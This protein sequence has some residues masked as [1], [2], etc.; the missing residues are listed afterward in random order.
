MS[1]RRAQWLWPTA[2]KGLP[3]GRRRASVHSVLLACLLL[4]PL[5]A[6]PA[7][8]AV[9]RSPR[10]ICKHI[11]DCLD[12]NVDPNNV[13][14]QIRDGVRTRNGKTVRAGADACATDL[15][16]KREWDKWSGGCSDIEY[17]TIAKA[18]IENGKA[19]CDRYSQ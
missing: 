14:V 18:E 6:A 19:L 17:V 13:V 5:I 10:N 9:C 7:A 11:A 2:C 3:R 8:H 1:P 15:G 4:S 12:R 16:I